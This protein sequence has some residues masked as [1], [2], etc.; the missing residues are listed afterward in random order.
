MS[1]EE[2][3]K[4]FISES[5]ELLEG[6]E[7]DL[8]GLE[9]ASASD[10]TLHAIFR[11]AH[12]VKGSAGLFGL[13][14]IVHFAHAIEGL[15]DEVRNHRVSVTPDRVSLLLRCKDHLLALV[16]DVATGRLVPNAALIEG[17][18]PLVAELTR[19][20]GASTEEPSLAPAAPASEGAWHVSVRFSP[21]ALRDGLDPIAFVRHLGTIGEVRGVALVEG[22]QTDDPTDCRLGF[23]LSLRAEVDEGRIEE[24]F[25]LAKDHCRVWILPPGSP[26]EAF[27]RLIDLLPEG[28]TTLDP[29][30][31]AS[32]SIGADALQ[33]ARQA[34]AADDVQTVFL[35]EDLE[36]AA[37]VN[38]APAPAPT[39]PDAVAKEGSTGASRAGLAP[40]S[41][42]KEG[43]T[44]RV[45]AE[46]LDHLI[47]LVGE[48]I[49]AAAG[50]QVM[51][52]RSSVPELEEV[53]STIAALVEEVRDSAL[54]LRMVKIGA[55]FARFPR[56]VRDVARDLGKEITLEV[57][58][59][60]TELDKT[61][62]ER[63]GDPLM[64]LVRN[65]LDHGIEPA[66]RRIAAGKSARGT[67]GL[68]AFHDSGSIVIEVRDDGGG[69]DKDRIFKKAVERGLV[70]AHEVLSDD[71]VY[72]LIFEPGFSTASEVTNIS[73]RGVG[74]DVVKRNVESMRGS[75]SVRSTP[76]QGTTVSLR[77]PL[78]LAI[79][80]GFL[81][82][83][84]PTTY[85]VPLETVDECVEFKSDG[86][87]NYANLRGEVLPIIRLRE[88]FGL[89]PS[90]QQRESIVV[91][92]HGNI[93]A[94]LVVD[95][96]IGEFQIVIKPLNRVFNPAR[97]ISGSTI[98]GS[99]EVGLIL[100]V[101]ALIRDAV[102]A[103]REL[104]GP[105]PE[106][107]ASV[108]VTSA[109]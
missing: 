59:E 14:H 22:P 67:L 53:N 69:L 26:P 96:L 73:G 24:A 5:R 95:T 42:A 25:G 82:G 37:E 62:V 38:P 91:L 71:Q 92:R 11:A 72:R 97:C 60:D 50:G 83:V 16:D 63:L 8:L 20:R 6:L 102:R 68:N 79:I 19:Q 88:V 85:V 44:L 32:G 35:F 89:P 17:S 104:G 23:E 57:S 2:V 15:L 43:R 33:R 29:M 86:G 21:N 12:T 48:L 9:Q 4:T 108:G 31:V 56:V 61:V 65:A 18:K 74:M 94:G 51:A 101:A 87:S 100:D 41:G 66:E 103:A 10:E 52:R 46:R 77:L 45:D 75:V 47:D 80:E 93:R 109:S 28:P 99:G 54:Q 40:D 98:L 3:I 58:G 105:P 13:E 30:I 78:T 7:R 55:T 81:V 1:A 70:E 90:A 76:G 107:A 39:G 36:A 84:G 27:L 106:K 34:A 49:I 64:H